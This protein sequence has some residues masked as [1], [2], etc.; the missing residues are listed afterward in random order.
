[1]GKKTNTAHQNGFALEKLAHQTH[2]EDSKEKNEAICSIIKRVNH[3][4]GVRL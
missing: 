1:V 3:F 4:F 2:S